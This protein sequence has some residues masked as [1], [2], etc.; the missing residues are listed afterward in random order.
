MKNAP[1]GIVFNEKNE[2]LLVLR[3]FPPLSWGP[4][5][6]FPDYGE[7]P[8]DTVEREVAEETGITCVTLA[9]LGDYEYEE[10]DARLNIYVCSYLFGTLRCSYESKNVGWFSLDQLPE[11]L[12]P[13]KEVF[14]KAFDLYQISLRI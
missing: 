6:G 4:P 7:N 13:P 5:G 10:Y 12:S 9:P 14:M 11:N 1:C 8:R 3:R 2:V